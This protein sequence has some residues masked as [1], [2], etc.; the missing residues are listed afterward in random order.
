MAERQQALAQRAAAGSGG[1]EH[2]VVHRRRRRQHDAQHRTDA[3]QPEAQGRARRPRDDHARAAAARGRR[4]R[5]PALPAAG[6]GP[7]DRGPRVAH[8][9]S[10]HAG[11]GGRRRAVRMDAAPR[12]AA[13]AGEGADRR[14]ERPAGPRPAGVRRHRPRDR[15][16][17][18]HHAGGDRQRAL[19]RVR[20]AAGVD[21]LHAGEP[22]PR[23]AGGEARVPAR[24][25]RAGA[26]LRCGDRRQ[27]G[28]AGFDRAASSE[29]ATALRDQPRRP[30]SGR[31]DLVQPRARCLARPGGGG[32]QGGRG[33]A[34][35]ARVDRD[36][37]PGRCARVPG[38]AHQHGA[39]D[40][41]RDRHDVHR[42]R[43]ALRELHPPDHDPVDAAFRRASA[44]CSR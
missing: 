23:R 39:A 30:V 36:Q 34:R 40:R 32:D 21:D 8:A 4:R 9:V 5:H 20:P 7:D 27:A 13:V 26:D 10:V 22:V 3:D 19:Q 31:D 29:R 12:R 28:A 33:G 11:I 24:P 15:G 42:A 1:R 17:A 37:L 18:W 2:L 43:R 35:D 14:R 41:R 6:A 25:R 44:R 16:P 38:V